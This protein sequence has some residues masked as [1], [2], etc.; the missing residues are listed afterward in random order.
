MNITSQKQWP[1]NVI[2]L[3]KKDKN[4]VKNNKNNKFKARN[5]HYKGINLANHKSNYY[6]DI[7][8]FNINKLKKT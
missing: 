8:A 2:I 1:Q 4:K 7:F 3:P 5:I 6:S